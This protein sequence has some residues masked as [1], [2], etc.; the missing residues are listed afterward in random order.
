MKDNIEIHHRNLKLI[1][2]KNNDL[3][4]KTKEIINF[5]KSINSSRVYIDKEKDDY[6]Y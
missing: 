2:E 3:S 4:N 6:E 5:S 1:E